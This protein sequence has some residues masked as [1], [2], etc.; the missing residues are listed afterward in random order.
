M[1][2][3]LIDDHQMFTDAMQMVIKDALP[4][5]QVLAFTS[6]LN[7]LE[8]LTQDQPSLIILD[9]EM[10]EFNGF[11]FLQIL[12]QHS[13][14]VPVL[15]CSGNLNESNKVLALQ[16][17]AK[18]FLTKSNG[19]EEVLTA[20]ASLLSGKTYPENIEHYIKK[21]NTT[22]LS[23]RQCAILSLMQSGMPNAKIAETLFLSTNT[24]KTH[25]RLMYN[26]LDVNS[27]IECLNKA[28]ELGLINN[29]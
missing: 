24:V 22:T 1:L 12:S 26:T 16:Y 18:G 6:P 28:K 27:R 25:I 4:D 21:I 29:L 20:I 10:A 7:A 5:Y 23:N 2:I 19:S 13:Y 17:G 11:S 15:V 14:Q 8:G 3:Y 9:L